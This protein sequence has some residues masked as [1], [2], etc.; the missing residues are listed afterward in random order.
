MKLAYL[1]LR[2]KWDN[3]CV[4]AVQYTNVA[5]LLNTLNVF[6]F[7]SKQTK[8][9]SYLYLTNNTLIEDQ[10]IGPSR[11]LRYLMSSRR[12]RKMRKFTSFEFNVPAAIFCKEKVLHSVEMNGRVRVGRVGRDLLT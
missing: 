12:R 4:T 10:V 5:G 1:P 8:T 3:I 2:T 7:N 11:I 6:L 9:E